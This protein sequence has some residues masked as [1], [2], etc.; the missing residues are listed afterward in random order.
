MKILSNTLEIITPTRHY[1]T[2][3]DIKVITFLGF[4]GE[5]LIQIDKED[6]ED[7]YV[8]F[9]DELGLPTLNADYLMRDNKVEID[10][11]EIT[12]WSIDFNIDPKD[13]WSA[14]T[15]TLVPAK[16]RSNKYVLRKLF[17]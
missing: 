8:K 3:P 16:S 10:G 5:V 9:Y 1:K 12:R 13:I 17:K 15:L 14:E 6:R 2:D 4:S 7:P 11:M